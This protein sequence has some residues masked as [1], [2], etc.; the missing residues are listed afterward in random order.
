VIRFPWDR[1]SRTVEEERD[2]DERV[3][4]ALAHLQIVLNELRSTLDRIEHKRERGFP[5]R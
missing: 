3:G 1:T 4:F 2:A 5:S